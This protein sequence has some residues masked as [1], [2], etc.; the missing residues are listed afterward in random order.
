MRNHPLECQAYLVQKKKQ[1]R[2][3]KTKFGQRCAMKHSE[4]NA[5]RERAPWLLVTSLGRDSANTRQVIHLYKTRMQ[6]EEAFRDIKNSRWG[7]S[8]NEA[9]G[10]TTYRYENLLLIAQLA[11]FAVWL[12]GHGIWNNTILNSTG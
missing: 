5:Q 4:K 9:R 8:F 6:I 11:H 2:I 7:F 10:T 1:G 3:K 12:I